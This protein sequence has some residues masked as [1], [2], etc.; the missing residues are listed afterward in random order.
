MIERIV[1]K[2]RSATITSATVNRRA[3][4]RG[5]VGAGFIIAGLG[6]AGRGS[7]FAQEATPVATGAPP[8][9]AGATLVASNL[10]NPR[11]IAVA[12]DGSLY[13]SEAGTG[14]DEQIFAPTGI[15]GSPEA[16]P[17]PQEP[18]GTRGLT[19]QVTQIAPDGTATVVAQGLPSYTLGPESTGPAGI[20]VADG[21]IWLAVG[22]PGP[23]AAFIDPIPNENSVVSIDPAT[24][25]V[26]LV[27]D[28]GAYEHAN[29]PHPA[30]IDSNLYGIALAD[31]GLL[32]VADAGGNAVYHVDPTSGELTVL[33]VIEDIPLPEGA[34]GPPMLQAVPTGVTANPAGGVYVGLLS[35]GPFPPGAA[36]V[37]AVSPDGTVADAAT[38]L[39]M[40][41][42]VKVGPD[43]NLYASQISTN[44][45]SEPPAPGSVVRIL[46]DGTQETVV[47]GLM[48]PNGIDFD[49]EGNLYVVA[50]AVGFGAPAGMVLRF[51]GVAVPTDATP[52]A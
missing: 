5:G 39:T 2:T 20:V 51:D 27:A 36:K 52:T 26:T 29:N 16:S 45:L 3:L 31:D 23:G 22:G 12:D 48:L 1:G 42:D 9:P 19:G 30:A 17:T 34:Q 10:L 7:A 18:F 8:L 28:I 25:T 33:A 14:G 50:G 32:H 43:G 38:G 21:T 44:F 40:V 37:L 49:A 6:A 15:E 24:G 13:V 11:F 46:A 35:G 4:V 47:D 41:V